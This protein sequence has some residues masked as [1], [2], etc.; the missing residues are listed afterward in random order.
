MHH[1]QVLQSFFLIKTGTIPPFPLGY[2]FDLP[3]A[4]M[5]WLKGGGSG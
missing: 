1:N 4:S 3:L 2:L 5:N